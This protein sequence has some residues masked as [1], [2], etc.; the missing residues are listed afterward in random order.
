V[1]RTAPEVVRLELQHR[2][3]DVVKRGV[4]GGA[5]EQT[6]EA[7]SIIQLPPRMRWNLNIARDILH[8]RYAAQS[9]ATADGELRARPRR[10]QRSG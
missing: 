10:D 2:A 9:D 3:V 8:R 7:V 1:E 4:G 6:D 5:V